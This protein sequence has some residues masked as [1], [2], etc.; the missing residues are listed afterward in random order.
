MLATN[1]TPNTL[2]L[3]AVSN[4]N[5]EIGSRDMRLADAVVERHVRVQS[6]T[7]DSTV[8]AQA[9]KFKTV[10]GCPVMVGMPP[11]IQGAAGRIDSRRLSADL[12]DVLQTVRQRA[13]RCF[14]IR[15]CSRGIESFQLERSAGKSRTP[16]RGDRQGS[17]SMPNT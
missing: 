9:G 17:P 7:T 16:S 1:A 2:L 10:P 15:Q 6:G 8:A 4:R 13:S 12:R 14:V 3:P 5:W 11:R